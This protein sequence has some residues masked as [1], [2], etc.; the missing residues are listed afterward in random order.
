MTNT[1]NILRQQ[2]LQLL[3]LREGASIAYMFDIDGR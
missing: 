3:Q 2:Q 1:I